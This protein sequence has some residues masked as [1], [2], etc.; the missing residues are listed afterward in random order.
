M[1]VLLTR[2]WGNSWYDYFDNEPEARKTFEHNSHYYVDCWLIEGSVI[3][4]KTYL[5][6]PFGEI[7]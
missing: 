7:Y 4:Q 5:N 6:T 3:E 1:W 2:S